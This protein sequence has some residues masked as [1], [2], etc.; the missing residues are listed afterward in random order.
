MSQASRDQNHVTTLLAVSS[1]DGVTPIPLYA[2]PVTHRLLIDNANTGGISSLSVAT[3]NGF[4]GNSS[5]GTTPIITLSTTI[6]GVLQG[7]GTAISAV[8]IGSGL[9][10]S[11]GTLSATGTSTPGGL[12]TQL[13]YNNVG[14][15]GGIS[16]ATTNGTIVSLTNPLIGGATITTSTI[17]G[18]TITTGTGI[19]TLA[20]GKTLT[21]SNT[22]TLAGTDG[23]TLNIGTGGTLGTAAYTAANT[24]GLLANPLSQFAATTSAQLAGVIS[25]ETGTGVLVFATS[26]TLVTPAL[27]T[28]T[29]LVATNA[30]GTAT[31]LT[32]GIT[33]AL[34][35]AT[36]TVNVSSATAPTSGQV[37]TATSGTAATWQTPTNGSS[38]QIGQSSTTVQPSGGAAVYTI[39]IPAGTLG[40]S[41][42]IG[43]RVIFSNLNLPASS[44][45][46]IAAVTYGGT[47]IGTLTFAKISGSY[48][49]GAVEMEGFIFANASASAQKTQL[50]GRMADDN[51]ASSP[52]L[53]CTYTATSVNSAIS[54]N[55]VVTFTRGTNGDCIAQG[56]V[57]TLI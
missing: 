7:N 11:G 55:L 51:S 47:S 49:S 2:D 12:N 25:D 27:G 53:I 5:G 23:S 18:N 14:S 30:T 32:S 48:N 31:S 20:A 6:T 33:Q 22:L 24:Y 36:T 56:I 21:I 34:A 10:F 9:S 37:L 15:F 1:V 3:T 39:T 17:N 35:S 19:L 43:F 44:D 28:P 45:S 40:T 4:S 29:A 50:I 8:T 13:Q 26:P 38:G 52:V 41:N 57:V 16:G 46:L 42:V 54:Q